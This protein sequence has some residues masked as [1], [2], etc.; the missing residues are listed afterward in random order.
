MKWT[1]E[2]VGPKLDWVDTEL[3]L[4]LTPGRRATYYDPEEPAY[5]ELVDVTV[6][7]TSIQA[8]ELWMPAL[9]F[10]LTSRQQSV[11]QWFKSLCVGRFGFSK[12]AQ[13]SYLEHLAL[14]LAEGEQSE[15]EE[16]ALEQADEA[17]QA[18]YDDHWQ[19]QL[20]ISRGK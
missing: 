9:L 12:Q 1:F 10:L 4:E 15:I 2:D 13:Q 16:T 19:H 3:E 18:A 20:D 14:D 5:V 17:E 8:K 6:E 11:W 7:E